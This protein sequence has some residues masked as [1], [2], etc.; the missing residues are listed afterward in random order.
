MLSAAALF[1]QGAG[2]EF[3]PAG[4]WPVLALPE[5][6]FPLQQWVLLSQGCLELGGERQEHPLARHS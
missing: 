5:P 1:S 4:F 2:M 3:S 6:R